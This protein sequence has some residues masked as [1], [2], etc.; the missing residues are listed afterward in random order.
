MARRYREVITFADLVV[1]SL[2]GFKVSGIQMEDS[3]EG[4]G[5]ICLDTHMR[6]KAMWFDGSFRGDQREESPAA[7]AQLRIRK[8]SCK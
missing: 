5:F 8:G 7:V 2:N 6:G 1:R 4:T 3:R